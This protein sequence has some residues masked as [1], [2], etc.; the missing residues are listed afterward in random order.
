MKKDLSFLKQNVIAHRGLHN[1]EIPENSIKAFEKAIDKNYIIE[2][3]VHLLK[4]GNIVVFHDDNL[5]R[6]AEINK[7]LKDCTYNELK[8]IKIL[9]TQYTIPKLESV[10]KIIDGRVPIIIELKYDRMVG[11]LEK[12]IVKILDNYKGRFC[13]KSFSPLSIIWFRINRPNYVRG[14]LISSRNRTLKE[15]IVKSN[16]M[17]TLSKPDFISCNYKLFNSK[18][19]NK[20]KKKIPIIAWTIKNKLNYLKYKDCFYNLICENIDSFE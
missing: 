16:L 19:I 8:D 3:D 14:L 15:R 13:I 9:N 10:L 20:Y 7:N 11:K 5:K 2:L 6:M 18:L 1:L 4:D 12:E 17:L